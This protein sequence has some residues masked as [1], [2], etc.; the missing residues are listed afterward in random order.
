MQLGIIRSKQ[1][2]SIRSEREIRSSL[3][4]ADFFRQSPIPQVSDRIWRELG[5]DRSCWKSMLRL[6]TLH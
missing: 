2:L 4:R 3:N 5:R 1:A 6:L